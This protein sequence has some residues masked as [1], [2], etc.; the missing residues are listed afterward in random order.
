[1][2]IEC[3]SLDHVSSCA[4]WS[5]GAPI[6]CSVE[7]SLAE[8][9]AEVL[10]RANGFVRRPPARS[11]STIPAKQDDRRRNQLTFIAVFGEK[12]RG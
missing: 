9:L 12:S 3:H 10:R 7:L 11:S 6:R 5:G 8:N 2:S 1:V 4:F